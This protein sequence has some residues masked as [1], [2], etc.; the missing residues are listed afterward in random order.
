MLKRWM[1]L[2]LALVLALSNLAFARAEGLTYA[3][4]LEGDFGEDYPMSMA[5]FKGQL[6][7]LGGS[8]IYLLSP[9]EG[10]VNL[11]TVPA[12][13]ITDPSHSFLG[14]ERLFSDEE[15]LLVYEGSTKTLHRVHL[16]K[17]PVSKAPFY[18][19]P[20]DED[21]YFSEMAY[22]APYLF[23]FEYGSRKLSRHD[24]TTQEVKSFVAEELRGM[25]PYKDG[26]LL[27]VEINRTE[28]GRAMAYVQYDLEAGERSVL[29]EVGD[30][31]VGS[32]I[33]YDKEKDLIYS[34]TASQ[35][36]SW[37]VG[38][39]KSNPLSYL[40]R[41]DTYGLTL[42][43]SDYAAI[44][45][46]GMVAVRSLIPG[47]A[48]E[49]AALKVL[50]PIGRAGDYT[51]FLKEH[52]ETELVFLDSG[53]LTQEERFI[54]DMLT[55]SGEVDIYL[56][57]DQN[58]ISQIKKKGFAADLT[59]APSVK[60][61]VDAYEKPFQDAATQDGKIL[62]FYKD[63]FVDVPVYSID[64]FK[65]LGF[66]PPTTF[67]EYY[68]LCERYITEKMDDNPEIRMDPFGNTLDLPTVLTQIAAEMIKNGQELDFETPEM[69][70]LITQIAKVA[71]LKVARS[72]D[73]MLWLF[74]DYYL[75]ITPV[76]RAF[77]LLTLKEGNAPALL[78]HQDAFNYFVINPFSKNQ[79]TALKFL[80][81]FAKTLDYNITVV[82]DT[83]AVL[84]IESEEY[85]SMAATHAEQLKS[86]EEEL[87]KL[88]G[89]E[90]SAMEQTIK[91][92]KAMMESQEEYRWQISPEQ[93]NIARRLAPEVTIP[94]FNPIRLLVKEY[95]D[96]FEEYLTN[97][98]FDPDQFLAQLNQMVRTALIEQE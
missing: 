91:D 38:E 14:M 66:E 7:V 22:G 51:R 44:F 60:E 17:D 5:S 74:Y 19:I 33:A 93:V 96:F 23:T 52:A 2:C 34:A 50:D 28:T 79:E 87:E 18:V 35:L 86:F 30:S 88:T 77:M 67:L 70:E 69:K 41:G 10:S 26:K 8:G 46:D 24:I 68:Q 64:L 40:P 21:V 15:G 73:A 20:G 32:S 65:E 85:A 36:F 76:D 55:Q 98:A 27:A 63:A 25:T 57:R 16:D 72:R 1:V 62:L 43:G 95:P 84:G 61:A 12:K 59:Q 92:H 89:A 42:I 11:L 81:S 82:R 29:G 78:P 37:R 53:T 49:R 80:E 39:E 83:R 90:K 9:T 75:P 6:Y 4:F 3:N 47:A 71:K 94:D 58:L 97:P 45:S 48:Q 13:D 54:N 31:N 56:L